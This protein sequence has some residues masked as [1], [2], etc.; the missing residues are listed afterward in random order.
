MP[1]GL[2]FGQEV[3]SSQKVSWHL[4]FFILVHFNKKSTQGHIG[5]F[6][7]FFF[8]RIAGLPLIWGY[9]GARGIEYICRLSSWAWFVSGWHQKTSGWAQRMLWLQWS[10][11]SPAFPCCSH[12]YQQHSR[13][14]DEDSGIVRACSSPPIWLLCGHG[15][16]S[17]P[18][19]ASYP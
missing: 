1:L 7:F 14:T 2:G 15:R 19:H 13:R 3:F 16:Y 10:A 12:L 17:K 9:R 8:F 6:F 5:F 18:N 11:A 4:R